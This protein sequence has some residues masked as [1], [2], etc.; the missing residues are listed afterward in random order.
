MDGQDYFSYKPR[1]RRRVSLA[2]GRSHTLAVSNPPGRV[3][4]M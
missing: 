1:F 2:G 3:F 4:E